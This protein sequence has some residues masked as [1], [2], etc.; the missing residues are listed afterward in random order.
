MLLWTTVNSSFGDDVLYVVDHLFS[1][2][3]A[4]LPGTCEPKPD[5][6]HQDWNDTCASLNILV[7]TECASFW[8]A[9]NENS[10]QA[11]PAVAAEALQADYQVIGISGGGRKSLPF[12]L[13]AGPGVCA[14]MSF[15]LATIWYQ[16]SSKE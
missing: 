14:K 12:H 10:L 8:Q 16:S 1:N 3:G 13:R 7:S 2:A 15:T 11:F 4:A 9:L 5:Q 6:L